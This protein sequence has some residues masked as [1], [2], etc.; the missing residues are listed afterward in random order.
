MA[1]DT[2]GA[3]TKRV[4]RG[5]LSVAGTAANV[6]LSLTGLVMLVVFARTAL[7][8]E[9][10]ESPLGDLRMICDAKTGFCVDV[11]EEAIEQAH[12]D[13]INR[14][15]RIVGGIGVAAS[16]VA[17]TL[18]WRK[19]S[20]A[21]REGDRAIHPAAVLTALLGVAPIAALVLYLLAEG[22]GA[23]VGQLFD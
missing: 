19:G 22:L 13:G 17:I 5:G 14:S 11:D 20:Q 4:T 3:S 9:A 12:E 6:A 7:V 18:G 16:C 15:N 1:D 8:H 21:W 2:V 10:Y 23:G